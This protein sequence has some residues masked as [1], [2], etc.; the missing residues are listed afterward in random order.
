MIAKNFLQYPEA[1][2]F[3]R[4]LFGG[5][6]KVSVRF[7]RLMECMFSFRQDVPQWVKNQA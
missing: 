6:V 7:A 3:Q 4:E 1:L 2:R 5:S